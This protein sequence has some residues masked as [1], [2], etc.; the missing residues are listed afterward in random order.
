[1]DASKDWKQSAI[2][3]KNAAKSNKD[4]N[5]DKKDYSMKDLTLTK[6]EEVSLK[7]INNKEEIDLKTEFGYEVKVPEDS[8]LEVSE[9]E[10]VVTLKGTK[11]IK[12]VEVTVTDRN[13]TDEKGQPKLISKFKVTVTEKAKDASEYKYEF[14]AIELK[15]GETKIIQY[16]EKSDDLDSTPELTNLSKEENTKVTSSNTEIALTGTVQKEF[17]GVKGVKA[18]KA[19]ITVIFK[20]ETH[21]IEVTVVEDSQ[22]NTNNSEEEVSETQSD[23]AQDTTSTGPNQQELTDAYNYLRT[24]VNDATR[25]QY[26]L[27]TKSKDANGNP[28]YKA[29]PKWSEYDK[30]KFIALL[31]E[32]LS[33]ETHARYA[34]PEGDRVAAYNNALK[35]A[36]KENKPFIYGYTNHTG[37]FFAA[38]TPMKV[39]GSPAEAEKE[40]RQQYKNCKVVYVVYPDKDFIESLNEEMYIDSNFD[41]WVRC[42]WCGELFLKEQCKYEVN[43]G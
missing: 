11:E 7:V 41:E 20:E 15:V 42:E 16:S 18:G 3:S 14:S 10:G 25:K 26:V 22:A 40:F 13:K 37:K 1:M 35:Y 31:G 23:S 32:S 6:G 24:K 17:L 29:G 39:T 2:E 5:K 28:I 43:F 33:E 38:E 30:S 34:K 27:K 8:G 19:T 21:T 12:D 4:T 9:K 36:K